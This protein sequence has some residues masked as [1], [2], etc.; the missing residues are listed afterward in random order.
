MMF[1]K[2]PDLE[3]LL[4]RIPKDQ[5][6]EEP[7][8][9]EAENPFFAAANALVAL[10]RDGALPEGFSLEEAV[11]DPA[12]AALVREFEPA[13]AV[14]IYAAERRAEQAEQRIRSEMSETVRARNA[15]PRS[16]RADRAVA[17]APDY[18]AMSD[19]AFRALEQQ[20]R[21]AAHSG[22]RVHI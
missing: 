16:G 22:K 15:L 18:M 13:A 6:A 1:K 21:T 11:Q 17:P 2:K 9:P 8:A 20:Y 12:F 5:A 19:E 7:A 4:D 14:R 3:T 10:E